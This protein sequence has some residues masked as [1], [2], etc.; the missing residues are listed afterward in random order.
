M[1]MPEHTPAPTP[2][3]AVYGFILALSSKLLFTIYLLW[4][5]IPEAWF[6][7]IGITY[8]IDRYWAIVIPIFL[9]TV[10]GLFTFIIYPSLGL[11][12]TPNW[13]DL[14]TISDEYSDNKKISVAKS[15]FISTDQNNKCNCYCSTGKAC[16]KNIFEKH[17][18]KEYERRKIPELQD[19]SSISVSKHLYLKFE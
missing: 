13:D 16:K 11:I 9:L 14:R 1:N 6:E 8:L 15:T 12:M 18:I 10:L 19:L 17:D 2:N 5:V 7:A 4:A 3:R